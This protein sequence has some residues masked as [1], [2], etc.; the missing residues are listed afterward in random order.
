LSLGFG[1]LVGVVVIVAYLVGI[2]VQTI[3]VVLEAYYNL[4]YFVRD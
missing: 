3:W 2:G 4:L 1:F